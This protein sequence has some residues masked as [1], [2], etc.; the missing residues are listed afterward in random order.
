[1]LGRTDSGRRL[2]FLLL[3][4]VLLGG[5][6]VTRLG[7]WQ[8]SQRDQ[9]VA[10]AQRQIS[11]QLEIPSERGQ[12]FDRSGTIV[13]ATNLTRQTL[14]VSA[15]GLTGD[16]QAN[17]V[18]FLSWQLA[19]D[20]TATQDLQAKI[21]TGKPYLVIAKDLSSTQASAIAA[22][23]AAKGIPGISFETTSTRSYPQVGGSPSS[24]LAAQLIGF[25]NVDG[26]GQYGVEQY[27]QDALAGQPKVVEADR[28]ANGQ[29]LLDTERTVQ[30]GVSGADLRL[31]IDAS[32]QLAV[33]QEAMAAQIADHAAGVSAVVMDPYTGELYAEASYP[34]YDANQY[35][36]VAS[37]DPGRFVDP[38]VS[39]VYE[40]GSVFK[41]MTVLAALE[42][43]TATLDSTYRDSGHLSLDGGKTSVRDADGRAMGKMSLAD[44]IA[45]SRNVVASKVALGLSDSTASS[46]AILHEVWTRLGFGSPTGID[47][48]GEVNGL[49]NDP[50][51]S[52]WRQIDLAN[53]SFGQGVAVTE[54]QLATAYTALINGGTLVQP[55]VVASVDGRPVDPGAGTRVID[56]ATSATLDDLL[57]HVLDIPWYKADSQVPGYWVGGKTGTAQV[58]DSSRSRWYAD[59]YNFSC[60]GFIGRQQGHPDL[61]VAILV[62]E[63]RPTWNAAGQLILPVSAPDVFRRVATDAITTPGLLQP[64]PPEEDRLARSG[65]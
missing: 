39:D 6:L 19:L 8:I 16:D 13:L 28:D 34:S 41:L 57:H 42:Q 53:G 38:I 46:A 25:V 64:L 22:A 44:A 27:Y 65:G 51:I 40:P 60:V 54:I 52:A 55:H 7:Y 59:R 63:G 45:Y 20:E 30:P 3:V 4:F 23:A 12:I 15:T 29:P 37:D 26:Q 1:M 35:A 24:S 33:E 9:L 61:V 18:H 48:S 49:V 36:Q 32:L 2:L 58:W 5:S 50:A 43:G 21:A 10:S 62:R 31:T 17:L 11:L 56:P 47:V 14:I